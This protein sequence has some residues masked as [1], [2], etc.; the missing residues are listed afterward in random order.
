MNYQKV[1][2][3]LISVFV[4]GLFFLGLNSF[5]Q[6]QVG[7]PVSVPQ[8]FLCIWIASF[9]V[10][11]VV[12][13]AVLF[14]KKKSSYAPV[15]EKNSDNQLRQLQAELLQTKETMIKQAQE[16]KDQR[17]AALN[18][19]EDAD[20]A[21]KKAERTSA[22]LERQSVIMQSLLE[23]LH[24][25]NKK[26]VAQLAAIVESSY[27]AITGKTLDGVITSW[28]RGA[29]QI[30]G[31]TA[32]EMIGKN[33]SMLVPPGGH[34]DTPDIIKKIREG[35]PV[36]HF[37]TRRMHKDGHVIDIS[38]SLSS[39]KDRNG[40]VI[41]ASSI[42][43]DITERKR[44]ERMKDEFLQTVSHE[45]RTP[46]AIIKM[47]VDNLEGDRLW[48]LN[49]EEKEMIQ[50]IKRNTDRLERL[51]N[52]ILDLSRLESKMTKINLIPVMIGDF[53]H[54]ILKGFDLLAKE[55][56]ITISEDFD[57]ESRVPVDADLLA[58]V[59]NNLLQNAMRYA[60]SHVTVM[61]KKMDGYL[62]V[63]VIDDGAG[64][65]PEFI[66]SLFNKFMQLNRPVG[67][68]GYKGTG[69]GLA[70]CREI[71]DLHKGA[72]WAE[73]K[74]GEGSQFHFNLPF[75]TSD[76]NV[77]KISEDPQWQNVIH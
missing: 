7:M 77:K 10:S 71:I 52:N 57:Q 54:D 73:S 28:N 42:A 33:I 32:E 62:R 4:G 11:S 24:E 13:Q 12:I 48:K 60:K 34:N 45:L 26:T 20:E 23:D 18:M 43:R 6:H 61:T 37:E 66:P 56:A 72:I 65:K 3:T 75:E 50:A 17:L 29:E 40:N 14:S 27:D 74:V 31:Y 41:G 22:Q 35:I 70:I 76:S 49:E 38:L 30:Y 9:V 25:S 63:S 46:L 5:L 2:Q 55:E 1:Q 51:I 47:G 8:N 16:L 59:L 58:R 39:V 69:L 19:M 67:G 44:L 36:K 53:I 15:P 21:R 64:I 68:G